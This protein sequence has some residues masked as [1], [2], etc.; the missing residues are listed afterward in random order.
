MSGSEG[1]IVGTWVPSHQ[2]T[3]VQKALS[4]R[5]VVKLQGSVHLHVSWWE[6]ILVGPPVSIP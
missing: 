6:G 4:K 5:K 1:V 3:E 2:L